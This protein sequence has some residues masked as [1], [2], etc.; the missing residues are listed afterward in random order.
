MSNAP[1]VRSLFF[2]SFFLLLWIPPRL[3]VAQGKQIFDS[4]D[5]TRVIHAVSAVMIHDVV[6]PTSASRYYAY[7]TLPGYL[8]MMQYDAAE[9]KPLKVALNDFP[10]T[11]LIPSAENFNS[12]LA[13]IY[14]TVRMGQE[15]LPSG[16]LLD[17]LESEVLDKAQKKLG[18]VDVQQTVDYANVLVK[19]VMSYA[20]QDRFREI[21]GYLKYT[22]LNSDSTWKPTPPAYM[23]ALDPYWN[24]LRPFTLDSASQFRPLPFVPFSA[25]PGS[26]FYRLARET[27]EI[28]LNLTE[29]QKAIA[30]FWDCNPFALQQIGHIDYG[31][32]KIS[33]GGHWMSITGIACLKSKASFEKTVQAHTLVGLALADAFISCWDEKYRGHRIRPETFINEKMDRSWRP[34][35]Q[36]PPFPEYPSGHSVA[37]NAAATV[38]TQLFGENFAYDDHTE[39]EF[40]LPV[41]SFQSFHQAA[42]EASISRLYGG[43]HFRDGVLNGAAQGKKVGEQVLKKFGL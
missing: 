43:I 42:D 6:A 1:L 7:A 20:V 22:P 18:P 29:E 26:A 10:A 39:V 33:P 25:D 3:A 37:S 32:K 41:R 9:Y 21:F 2:L 27:Y 5:Y 15:L 12:S 36:T 34:L 24:R 17:T 35:L 30:N 13:I 28:G 14:A 31:V 11:P 38:L 4:E 19:L 40:D 8:V 16:F 23:Q